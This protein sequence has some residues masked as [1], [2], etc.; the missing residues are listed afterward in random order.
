MY[1]DIHIFA[2]PFE[3]PRGVMQINKEY[4]GLDDQHKKIVLESLGNWL[5]DEQKKVMDFKVQ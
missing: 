5:L 2:R 4:F 3:D 1:C